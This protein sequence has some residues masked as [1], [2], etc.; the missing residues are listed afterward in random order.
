MHKIFIGAMLRY[1]SSCIHTLI[2]QSRADMPCPMCNAWKRKKTEL[3][4]PLNVFPQL[5]NQATETRR[6]QQEFHVFFRSS[7]HFAYS[8]SN[9]IAENLSHRAGKNRL[10]TVGHDTRTLGQH[11]KRCKHN[12]GNKAAAPRGEVASD[13]SSRARKSRQ[14]KRP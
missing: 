14:L 9:F 7:S 11:S 2:P 8:E 10:K 3:F 5:R 4:N 12:T 1:L 6:L 13:W